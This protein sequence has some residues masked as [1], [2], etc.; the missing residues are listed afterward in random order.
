MCFLKC[1]DMLWIQLLFPKF[2]ELVF[3]H[4]G[5]YALL[6]LKLKNHEIMLVHPRPNCFVYGRFFGQFTSLEIWTICFNYPMVR[7]Y[8][9]NAIIRPG[10]EGTTCYLLQ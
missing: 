9:I 6:C 5:F 4:H 1:T 10:Y 2:L 8:Q 7:V 3:F